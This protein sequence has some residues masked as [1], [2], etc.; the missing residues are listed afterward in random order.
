MRLL[1]DYEDKAEDNINALYLMALEHIPALPYALLVDK[2]RWT[3]F[4]SNAG[5]LNTLWWNLQKEF[6]NISAPNER[7]ATKFDVAGNHHVVADKQYLRLNYN[8]DCIKLGTF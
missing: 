5:D 7:D 4:D 8:F 2:W 1:T 3:V 6:M